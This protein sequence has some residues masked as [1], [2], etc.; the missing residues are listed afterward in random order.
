[1]RKMEI[2]YNE[3]VLDLP[4]SKRENFLKGMIFGNC[5]KLFY[6]L[7]HDIS[8][9]GKTITAKFLPLDESITF[10]LSNKS[11]DF[12]TYK[13]SKETQMDFFL[14]HLVR[15]NKDMFLDY[16]KIGRHTKDYQSVYYTI[17]TEGINKKGE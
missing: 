16:I 5:F 4:A 12:I 3:L 2:M 7:V 11:L 17:D 1:M 13:K 9:V 10:Q 15:F 8:W 6:P 14:M